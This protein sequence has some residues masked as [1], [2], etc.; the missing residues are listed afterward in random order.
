M[1][2]VGKYIKKLRKEKG[3][4]Q[5]QLAEKLNITFQSVSKWE[6][7]ETLPDTSIL[8]DLCNELDITV[9]TLLNAGVIINKKRKMIK[10]ESIVEGFNH[11]YAVKECFGEDSDFYKGIVE[12]ISMK[13]N[14]DF[15]DALKNYPEVLYTEVVIGYILN[16]Y[17][18]DIEEAKNWIINEKYINEIK[19]RLN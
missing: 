8:L 4:T 13:M 3:L 11:L 10:V 7:G 2:E 19:K 18:I 16:G 5:N 9:D 17:T 6:T 14:F 12:G 15:E 1:N